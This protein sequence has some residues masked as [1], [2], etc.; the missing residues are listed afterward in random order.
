MTNLVI[1]L[2]CFALAIA[3]SFHLYYVLGKKSKLLEL[4]ANAKRS[5]G[6]IF[7]GV[8]T[9]ED[10]DKALDKAGMFASAFKQAGILCF[11]E[12]TDIVFNKIIAFQIKQSAE[13]TCKKLFG[14]K[15]ELE[16]AISD[17]NAK[18]PDFMRDII[19]TKKKGVTRKVVRDK[20]GHFVKKP[21]SKSVG[22]RLSIMKKSK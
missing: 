9:Q 1:A 8:E 4:K 16:K 10:M 19:R 7:V 20:K 21:H 5:L 22:R 18:K 6:L 14:K 17:H 3:L 13:A 2:V 15:C 11:H 12:S